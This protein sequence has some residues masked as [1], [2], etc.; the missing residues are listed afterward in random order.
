MTILAKYKKQ[1]NET[2]DYD[3]SYAKFFSTRTDDIATVAVT[4]ETGLMVGAKAV[5]GKV[6][7][8]FPSGGTDGVAYKVTVVMTSTSGVIKEDEFIV[9]VKEI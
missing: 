1:P 2:L 5:L 6:C 3:I 9:T 8:V 7:K 4:A